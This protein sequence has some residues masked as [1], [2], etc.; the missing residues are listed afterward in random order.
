MAVLEECDFCK[1]VNYENSDDFYIYELGIYACEPGY[2]YV[3]YVVN[4][5]ILHFVVKGKGQ[6]IL[7]EKE[8][9]LLI[10]RMKIASKLLL[11]TSLTIQDIANKVGYSDVF[12]F[13]KAFKRHTGKS[14]STYR[15][16]AGHEDVPD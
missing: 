13:T 5:C 6:L 9:Y 10:Y 3:Y 15:H 14:P 1:F 4:R 8:E 16:T 2:S 7:D 12:T 11:D